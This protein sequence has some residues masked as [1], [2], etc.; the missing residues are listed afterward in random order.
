MLVGPSIL[1]ALDFRIPSAVPLA[2]LDLKSPEERYRFA[3]RSDPIINCGLGRT[4]YSSDWRRG[5]RDGADK[6]R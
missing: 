5:A 6:E 1:R 2:L 4:R 3:M